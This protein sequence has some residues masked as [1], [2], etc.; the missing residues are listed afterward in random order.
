[1]ES[2]FI[3]NSSTAVVHS[4]EET[5]LRK[6]PNPNQYLYSEEEKAQIQK[7]NF[8][9]GFFLCCLSFLGMY[10]ALYSAQNISAV[11]FLRD[12]Y[13]SLGFYSNAFAYLGEGFGSIICVYIIMKM[14]SVKSMSRFAL[15][16][17]PFIICLILPAVKSSYMQSTNFLLSDGFVFVTVIIASVI[18]GFAMGIV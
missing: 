13:E 10:V 3:N 6:V 4:L 12:G 15:G 11:L 9:R 2:K 14:G 1:M 16:N 18:N 17:L 8:W 7:A 5:G